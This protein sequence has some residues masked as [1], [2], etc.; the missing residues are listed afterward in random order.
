M[1]KSMRQGAFDLVKKNDNETNGFDTT[2]VSSKEGYTV[3]QTGYQRLLKPGI[4]FVVAVLAL[5][6]LSPLFLIVGFLI[7]IDSKGPVFFRQVRAVTTDQ[8][9]TIYKFRTMSTNAPKNIATRNL[10]DATSYI[11]RIGNF[12]RKTSIDELPQLI[13]VIKG[14]MSIIGP[15]PVVLAEGELLQLRSKLGVGSVKAGITGLAQV[16]GRDLVDVSEKS[17]LD[18]EYKV[19]ISFILDLKLVFQTIFVVLLHIGIREGKKD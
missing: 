19:H 1:Q 18:Y 2:A 12:L 11:T 15:R 3:V 16:S 13:N 9:F 7:K 6:I 14:D 17:L 4:D 8:K 10:S 5:I